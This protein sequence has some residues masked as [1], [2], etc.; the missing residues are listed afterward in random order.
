MAVHSNGSGTGWLESLDV[1]QPHGLDYREFNDFRIGIRKR[2]QQEHSAMADVT[3]GG[4]HKP[5]GAAV[6]GMELTSGGLSDVTAALVNAN[7]DGTYRGHGLVWAFHDTSNQ[8]RLFCTSATAGAT[9]SLD[10][11]VMFLHPDLQWGGRDVTWAGAHTFAGRVDMSGGVHINFNSLDI[12]GGAHL[13]VGGAAGGNVR[14]GGDCSVTGVLK[15]DGTATEFGE[16]VK[17]GLFYDPTIATGLSDSDGEMSFPNG[18]KHKWGEIDCTP[19]VST[20]LFADAALGLSSFPSHCF[21]IQV[22]PG[23]SIGTGTTFHVQSCDKDGF[24]IDTGSNNDRL[25]RF[26]A[27]GR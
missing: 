14:F 23:Q 12:S 27:I 19:G 9:A 2:L 7:L 26:F 11:T 3:V 8:G 24:D 15:T 13:N 25:M 16:W 20:R 21:Q 1:D 22:T 17:L 18:V 5:G 6:V 4:I 10:Y